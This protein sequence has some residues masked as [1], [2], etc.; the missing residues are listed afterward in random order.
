MLGAD[1][2][3]RETEFLNPRPRLPG[4]MLERS[5]SLDTDVLREGPLGSDAT[6]ALT[7]RLSLDREAR[8]VKFGRGIVGVGLGMLDCVRGTGSREG[9]G[10]PL[11]RL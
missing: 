1:N 9:R 5:W 6:G 8:I 10:I 11:G 4:P 2:C 7:A 3:S